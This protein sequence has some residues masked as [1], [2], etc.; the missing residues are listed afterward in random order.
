MESWNILE[1]TPKD[2]AVQILV[3][4]RTP[5]KSHSVPESVVQTFLELWQPWYYDH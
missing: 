1:R 3:L 2:H 4:H 5:Q